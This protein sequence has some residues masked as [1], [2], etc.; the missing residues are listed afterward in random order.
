MTDKHTSYGFRRKKPIRLT[1]K[2][3]GSGPVFAAEH[4]MHGGSQVRRGRII[5]VMLI[6][7]PFSFCSKVNKPVNELL[8]NIK[9]GISCPT[10][11]IFLI[12]N[13]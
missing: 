8:I 6:F 1:G 4:G 2:C 13:I 12:R 11:E 7:G 3:L 10:T 9:R 5:R